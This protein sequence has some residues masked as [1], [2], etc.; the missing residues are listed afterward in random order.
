[1]YPLTLNASHIISQS[2]SFPFLSPS[3]P[4]T[5]AKKGDVAMAVSANVDN[6]HCKPVES[7]GT[8]IYQPIGKVCFFWTGSGIGLLGLGGGE[9]LFPFVPI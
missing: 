9:L 6:I 8:I 4:H 1:M 3:S 5:R 7:S 2:V